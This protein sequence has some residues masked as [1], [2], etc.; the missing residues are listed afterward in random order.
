MYT[1]IFR[2]Y[3]LRVSY[4]TYGYTIPGTNMLRNAIS[5]RNIEEIRLTSLYT[6]IEFI[7]L[8]GFR[9]VGQCDYGRFF[10]SI[11]ARIESRLLYYE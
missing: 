5:L 10:P 1:Y 11:V 8:M 2:V 9:Y 7:W 6:L 4:E 3:L